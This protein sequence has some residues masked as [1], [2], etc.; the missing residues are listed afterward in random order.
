MKQQALVLL[1]RGKGGFTQ[2][3]P[4]DGQG[5]LAIM[6]RLWFRAYLITTTRFPLTPALSP[7]AGERG[8]RRL[9]W[10]CRSSSLSPA[11]GER[12]RVRGPRVVV[13][14]CTLWLS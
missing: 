3:R 9:L 11:E 6:V 8:N 1:V 13:A 7:S 10:R 12:A 2:K 4:G 5:G 14:R